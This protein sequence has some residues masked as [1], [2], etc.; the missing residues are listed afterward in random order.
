MNKPW[1]ADGFSRTRPSSD[2]GRPPSTNRCLLPSSAGRDSRLRTHRVG[3]PS[4][5]RVATG[6]RGFSCLQLRSWGST[7][8][9]APSSEPSELKAPFY[10]KE[11]EPPLKV[12][13]R[14]SPRC[15]QRRRSAASPSS[16]DGG[17]ERKQDLLRD[18]AGTETKFCV[19]C[20]V[21]RSLIRKTPTTCRA[22]C[23]TP[24]T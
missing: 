16:S 23:R 9:S 18:W 4:R 8:G 2:T 13:W 6:P 14:F 17:M 5:L 3:H 10:S 19:S 1:R 11:V 20:S 24:G 21:L 7:P 12:C 15:R 22:L